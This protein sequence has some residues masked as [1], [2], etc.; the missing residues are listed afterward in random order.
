MVAWL[1]VYNQLAIDCKGGQWELLES[2]RTDPK[3]IEKGERPYDGMVYEIGSLYREYPRLF[4]ELATHSTFKWESTLYHQLKRLYA[5]HRTGRDFS[6]NR[7]EYLYTRG[8][9]VDSL[10]R[11]EAFTPEQLNSIDQDASRKHSDE[12]LKAIALGLSLESLRASRS[13]YFPSPYGSGPHTTLWEGRSATVDYNGA[14]PPPLPIGQVAPKYLPDL[15]A[16]AEVYLVNPQVKGPATCDVQ[17]NSDARFFVDIAFQ[18]VFFRKGC[19]PG[20]QGSASRVPHFSPPLFCLPSRGEC[21]AVFA[22]QGVNVRA[23][24]KPKPLAQQRPPPKPVA[25]PPRLTPA[26]AAAM[27]AAA[28]TRLQ[29]PNIFNPSQ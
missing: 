26:Q 24:F 7:I 5:L 2:R 4:A 17:G 12:K 6:G 8:L 13:P 11:P 16:G 18:L 1:Q 28:R 14:P 21:D 29:N 27:E 10:G 15:A 25:P 19:V 20:I 9:R 22:R 3:E 23:G